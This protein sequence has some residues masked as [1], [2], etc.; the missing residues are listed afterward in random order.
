M[1]QMRK[2]PDA[3]EGEATEPTPPSSAPPEGD[4]ELDAL[5]AELRGAL[6]PGAT[7]GSS[8]EAGN[9][10]A[11]AGDAATDEATTFLGRSGGAPTAPAPGERLGDFELLT[12]LG[13]GGMGVVYRAKQISLNR[14]VALKLLQAD[15]LDAPERRLR[16]RN[17]C[18]AVAKLSHPAIV[19]I[20][21]QGEAGSLLYY[22]MELVEGESLDRL[23]GRASLP[24]E[25]RGE[26]E[27]GRYWA[28]RFAEVAHAL[29]HAHGKQVFHRDIKPANLILDREGKLHIL[30]FGIARL[31]DD[32]RLTTT[33]QVLGTPAY[34]APEQINAGTE[35]GDQ[36][37]SGRLSGTT[38][39]GRGGDA[40][41]D[42][43]AL[44]VTLYETVTGTAPFRGQGVAEVLRQVAEVDPP[45]PRRLNPTI[46]RDL[47]AVILQAM[48][49]DPAKRYQSAAALGHDL[50]AVAA[51][52]PVKARR[53]TPLER[54]LRWARAHQALTAVAGA[55]VLLSV[56]L[57]LTEQYLILVLGLGLLGL[58]GAQLNLA[59]RREMKRLVDDS[60]RHLLRESYLDLETV[61][62]RLTR[63]QHLGCRS[64]DFQVAQA[65]TRL[66][67]APEQAAQKLERVLQREPNHRIAM[68]LLAWASRIQGN[69]GRCRELL[70]AAEA[71]GGPADPEERYLCGMVLVPLD[72]DRALECLRGAIAQQPDFTQALLHLGRALNQWLYEERRLD[73]YDEQTTCLESLCLLRPQSAYP[74]YL[75]SLA[76]RLA[77]EVH[78]E[79][80]ARATSAEADREHEQRARLLFAKA[81]EAAKQAQRLEPTSRRGYAAEAEYFEKTGDMYAAIAAWD[82]AFR[83]ETHWPTR[84]EVHQY[85]FRLEWWTVQLDRALW[86]LE[87]LQL[88]VPEDPFFTILYP[89]LVLAESQQPA[90]ALRR[91]QPERQELEDAAAERVLR[92]TRRLLGETIAA[93]RVVD[94]DPAEREPDSTSQEPSEFYFAGVELLTQGDGPGALRWL[95]AAVRTY[96]NEV[97][98][99]HA[100]ALATKLRR[101]PSWPAELVAAA[102]AV[103]PGAAGER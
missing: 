75:L 70:A 68:Y 32:P 96:D 30:D 58:V 72:I 55:G 23:I 28:A 35:H 42:V 16:F 26:G 61:K 89:A 9:E 51:S 91:L 47:E 93:G 22:A 27:A 57:L 69:V 74:R 52:A 44:G 97:Y 100:Q 17:E 79:T 6:G 36:Q 101:R 60:L 31:V 102:Q 77:A 82:N 76:H 43:Y 5:A 3:A 34:L 62:P 67:E 12:E 45:P 87:A 11:D 99:F 25:V 4:A 41:S 18:R 94:F 46:S 50:E 92:A 78:M 14:M 37:K 59:R 84:L 24:E 13:R 54:V 73:H 49:K 29:H 90:L 86:D 8:E 98:S 63:A 66:G 7:P 19:P 1:D 81:Y 71:A 2:Q 40:R 20:Y 10:E 48:R 83:Y 15:A 80:A 53:P 39:G 21:A 85:R 64:A 33:G 56:V 38:G 88:L 65:I 103:R 95:D